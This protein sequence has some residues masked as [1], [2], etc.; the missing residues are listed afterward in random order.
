MVTSFAPISSSGPSSSATASATPSAVSQALVNTMIPVVFVKDI[1]DRTQLKPFID[2][3]AQMQFTATQILPFVD[4]PAR[5]KLTRFVSHLVEEN[6]LD[7]KFLDFHTWNW[8]DWKR[9]TEDHFP[10][11]KTLDDDKKAMTGAQKLQALLKKIPLDIKSMD[12]GAYGVTMTHTFNLIDEY[13]DAIDK[14]T[15]KDT[16]K[17]QGG[18]PKVVA[19]LIVDLGKVAKYDDK[20]N[21]FYRRLKKNDAV[22]KVDTFAKFFDQ[23]QGWSNDYVKSRKII[24]ECDGYKTTIIPPAA[25]AG[26]G[27]GG[28]KR[29]REGAI[30]N[31]D[32]PNIKHHCQTCGG[33]HRSDKG[34]HMIKCWAI[35]QDHPQ[36]NKDPNVKWKDSTQGKIWKANG[37]D[38]ITYG[39]WANGNPFVT[40]VT[41]DLELSNITKILATTSE[42]YNLKFS[43][44]HQT[45]ER[46][47]TSAKEVAAYSSKGLIDTGAEIDCISK[48][49]FNKI[50]KTN[51]YKVEDTEIMLK[52]A[53]RNLSVYRPE[54]QIHNIQLQFHNQLTN[55]KEI[56]VVNDVLIVDSIYD[57]ILSRKTIR[58]ND[59]LR[60][61]EDEILQQPDNSSATEIHINSAYTQ[62]N[63][64]LHK[65]VKIKT[66]LASL[67]KKRKK[68]YEQTRK[69][70][71]EEVLLTQSKLC[72]LCKAENPRG[73]RKGALRPTPANICG[74]CNMQSD[75]K[76]EVQVDLPDRVGVYNK[77]QHGSIGAMFEKKI[78]S[79][80]NEEI[81]GL[82][83]VKAG[84]ILT[85]EQLWGI[86]PEEETFEILEAFPDT[87]IVKDD[88]EE[89]NKLQLRVAKNYK[90]R[91]RDIIYVKHIFSSI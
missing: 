75:K 24:N 53:F 44:P 18:Q 76:S 36:R 78:N 83:D 50:N 56:I 13:E 1:H 25:G 79:K 38:F 68:G 10:A 16:I 6:K 69:S 71:Q 19:E 27:G 87:F 37:K 61:C 7:A 74:E 40:R 33:Q 41:G 15:L 82:T 22:N 5:R 2:Y 11:L 26:N 67:P 73:D 32:A 81:I 4:E 47:W 51:E 72:T 84:D 30:K 85:K 20:L 43:I 77:D 60:K 91:I 9:I 63:E 65:M 55:K 62:Y 31:D 42:I 29:D 89:F 59:L 39:Q 66:I 21:Q 88:E 34:G 57:V 90:K 48:S 49:F 23:I 46:N 14:E 12:W 28:K 64:L 70:V 45:S 3:I 17:E 86:V 58:A 8:D 35:K 52:S 54:G 80:E